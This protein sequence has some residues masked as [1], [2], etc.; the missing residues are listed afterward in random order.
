MAFVSSQFNSFSAIQ[1]QNGNLA[2][3]ITTTLNQI[4]AL[5]ED[6][7]STLLAI[8][9]APTQSIVQKLTAKVSAI[10]GQ[11]AQLSQQQQTAAAQM[12]AQNIA[13]QNNKDMA[14]QAANQSADHELSVSLQNIMQ[15]EGQV[16]SNRT[17]YQ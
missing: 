15:W 9:A 8:Q 12:V 1:N 17:E 6:K 7:A 10:D 5:Q 13:N 4:K 3:V 2:N 16:T 14:A 11:I